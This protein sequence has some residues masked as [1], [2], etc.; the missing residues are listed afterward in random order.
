MAED[1]ISRVQAA[2][3]LAKDTV[4][5][6]E[7]RPVNNQLEAAGKL[8]RALNNGAE[9]R[10]GTLVSQ[11]SE[12]IADKFNVFSNPDERTVYQTISLLHDLVEDFKG[13][14]LKTLQ[15]IGFSHRI[16]QAVDDIT[17]RKDR[18]PKEKYFDFIK[19]LSNNNDALIVKLEDLADNNDRSH[20]RRPLTLKQFESINKHIIA[21]EYLMAVQSG[22]I[23]AG[24]SMRDFIE[25][26]GFDKDMEDGYY[27]FLYPVFCEE[28]CD[29]L[30]EDII[31]EKARKAAQR[32]TN[33]FF[34]LRSDEYYMP[35]DPMYGIE[36]AVDEFRAADLEEVKKA[37]EAA[38]EADNKAA[39]FDLDD[40]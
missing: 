10:D 12:R 13:L 32:K 23:K 27:E 14:T 29:E 24:S 2:I 20:D 5:N 3:E 21:K 19:R 38:V 11:H 4:E 1:N 25:D 34:A 30:G 31:E 6:G 18:S 35:D 28:F 39:G 40:L 16:V 26:R 7:G 33:E 36:N 15:D 17:R 8:L 9:R 22:E 37:I